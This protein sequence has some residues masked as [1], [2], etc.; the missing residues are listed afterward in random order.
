MK[1]HALPDHNCVAFMTRVLMKKNLSYHWKIYQKQ[2]SSYEIKTVC[3][4]AMQSNM[5]AHKIL[6]E[7]LMNK[8]WKIGAST[9]IFWGRMSQRWMGVW[10]LAIVWSSEGKMRIFSVRSPPIVQSPLY[11]FCMVHPILSTIFRHSCKSQVHPRSPRAWP[12]LGQPEAPN[13]RHRME[14]HL[15]E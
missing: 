12:S 15:A 6:F 8:N 5:L 13:K 9:N 14:I 3:D 11:S 7:L 10:L 1:A 4:P 2:M